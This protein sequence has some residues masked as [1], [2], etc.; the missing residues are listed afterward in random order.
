VK[1]VNICALP[2]NQRWDRPLFSSTFRN[3]AERNDSGPG[4]KTRSIPT[5]RYLGEPNYKVEKPDVA[6]CPA[7]LRG[8]NIRLGDSRAEQKQSEAQSNKSN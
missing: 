1:S 4:S 2:Q 6:F 3:A 7:T 8:S 5:N